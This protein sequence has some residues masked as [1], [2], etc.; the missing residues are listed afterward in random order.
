MSAVAGKPCLGARQAAPQPAA[1]RVRARPSVRQQDGNCRVR[2]HMPRHPA[3]DELAQPPMPV[4][5]HHQC[6]GSQ[7]GGAREQRLAGAAPAARHGLR[8]RPPP[9]A[10]RDGPPCRPQAPGQRG[11]P[12]HAGRQRQ[13]R[14]ARLDREAAGHRVRRVPPRANRPKPRAFAPA[15]SALRQRARSGSAGPFPKMPSPE[16]SASRRP[17]RRVRGPSGRPPRGRRGGRAAR[18]A[19]AA[20]RSGPSR[21]VSRK[22][23]PHALPALAT[24]AR[25]ASFRASRRSRNSRS[26]GS[27]TRGT[28]GSATRP[29]PTR[30]APNADASAMAASRWP[31]EA[32][33]SSRWTIRSLIDMANLVERLSLHPERAAASHLQAR[34]APAGDCRPPL[35]VVAIARW[36]GATPP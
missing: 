17:P 31:S 30:R 4:A 21:A 10:G 14:P 23:L 11:P 20:C 18:I 26:G 34:R 6:V 29:S 12:G 2:E 1:Y 16:A 19:P 28:K 27:S 24:A 9:R 8:S 7:F 5:A 32:A 22:P 33:P 15:A 25:S 36:R 3:Q 13:A 35:G